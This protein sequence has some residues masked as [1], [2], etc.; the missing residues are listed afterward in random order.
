MS[1]RNHPRTCREVGPPLL[2]DFELFTQ[3]IQ[4]LLCVFTSEDRLIQWNP[5]EMN[6]LSN[7]DS[8]ILLDGYV[9]LRIAIRDAPK[10][11]RHKTD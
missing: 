1:V 6:A 7:D 3:Q 10:G 11:R 8:I 9:D 2:E 5:Q 4:G